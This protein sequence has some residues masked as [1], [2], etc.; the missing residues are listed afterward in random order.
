MDHVNKRDKEKE[1]ISQEFI[2]NIL[3]KN[4]EF[5][6]KFNYDLKKQ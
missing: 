4:L 3:T 2:E 6:R 5:S 1:K